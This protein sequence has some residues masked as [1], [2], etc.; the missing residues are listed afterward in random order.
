MS[1]ITNY[2][3]LANAIILQAVDDYRV[4]LKSIRANPKSHVALS[5]KKE[6][7]RFFRSEWFTVLT[8]I[9]GDLLMKKL[10][11]EVGA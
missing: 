6:I 7:E 2:E 9:D 10:Q 1:D 4:A 11:M 3:K 5:D 8:G